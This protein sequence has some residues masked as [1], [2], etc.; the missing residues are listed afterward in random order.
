MPE[1]IRTAASASAE[2]TGNARSGSQG[3]TTQWERGTVELLDRIGDEWRQLCQEGAC[4]QPFFRP[5][6]IASSIRAFASKH[7][8]LLLTVRDGSRL[9]AVLPLLEEKTRVYGLAVTKLRSAANPNHSARFDFVHGQG[10]GLEEALHAGWKQLK[11]Q[12]DWDFIELVNVPEGGAAEILLRCA[13]EDGFL[14]YQYLWARTP[15]IVLNGCKSSA[16]FSQFA[17]SGRFRYKLR[18]RWRTL[19]KSGNLTL[20]RVQFADPEILLQFYGLEQSGWKGKRGTAIACDGETRQFYDSIAN[21]AARYGYLSLYFLHQGDAV[22]AAHFALTYGGRYYPLKI[23]YDETYSQYGPGHLIA[24]AVLRDCKERGL[25][26]FDWLGHWTEAKGEWASEV[27]PHNFC[28]IFRPSFTGRILHAQIPLA[29]RLKDAFQRL[30]HS[31]G[32]VRKGHTPPNE[33]V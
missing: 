22:V 16:D 7:P 2:W 24:G 26:E 28:Y 4:D 3:S 5:E 11:N 9:R 32:I 10:P 27:R 23:A 18:H 13:R 17:R 15:Y 25:S 33:R 14:T 12:P 20:R 30:K 19:E 1:P 21:Y 8:V 31:L 29:Y 6:W